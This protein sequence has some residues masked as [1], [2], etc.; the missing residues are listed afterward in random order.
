MRLKSYVLKAI[1]TPQNKIAEIIGV[2][3]SS[4]C[5]ELKRHIGQRGYRFKQADEMSGEMN[6]EL[7]ALIEGHFISHESIYRY[8][9]EDKKSGGDL[10]KKLR[11]KGKKYNK[12]VSSKV[13][14]GCIPRVIVLITAMPSLCV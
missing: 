9:C 12:R 14:R 13:G 4:V 7:I 10:Y 8:I 6:S 3:P 5:R 11:R 2:Q 1:A